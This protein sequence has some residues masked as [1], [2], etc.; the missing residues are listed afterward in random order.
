[1]QGYLHKPR[2]RNATYISPQIQN[3]ILSVIG[4]DVIRKSIISEIKKAWHFSVMADEVSSHN[5][6]H[7]ALCLR[8]V[9]EC[10]DIQEKFVEFIK[11]PRV[12]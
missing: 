4:F 11:L 7:L 8:Y 12:I 3:E 6:E 9:D 2:A 1:L 5:V 10:N